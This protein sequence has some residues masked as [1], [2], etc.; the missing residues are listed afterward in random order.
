M[1]ESVVDSSPL[2]QSILEVAQKNPFSLPENVIPETPTDSLTQPENILAGGK[3]DKSSL[4]V[5]RKKKVFP[6]RRKW[7]L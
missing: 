5:I 3:V 6:L 4:P 2:H 7:I 1:S